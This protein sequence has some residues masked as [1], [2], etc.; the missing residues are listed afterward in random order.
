[1]KFIRRL[2]ISSSA[3]W[4]SWASRAMRCCCQPFDTA[5][6]RESSDA[7]SFSEGWRSPPGHF[8]AAPPTCAT[9]L[10]GRLSLVLQLQIL[11]EVSEASLVVA[12][13]GPGLMATPPSGPG[14]H[15]FVQRHWEPDQPVQ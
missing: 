15:R 13:A 10:E 4:I 1:M 6:S 8:M 3:C 9:P 11:A 7:R 5:Q 14:H 12:V 2:C